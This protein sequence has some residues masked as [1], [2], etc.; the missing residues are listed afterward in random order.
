[1]KKHNVESPISSHIYLIALSGSNNRRSREDISP[2]AFEQVH[3]LYV[4]ASSYPL[5][6]KISLTGVACDIKCC[7]EDDHDLEAEVSAG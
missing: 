2:R 4:V 1:M 5:S 6:F 7:S 3:F